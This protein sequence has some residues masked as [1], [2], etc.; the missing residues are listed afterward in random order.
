[1]GAPES[2]AGDDFH[3]WWAA[4]RAL[5]LIEPGAALR[6]ITLEGLASVDDPD[7]AYETVDVAEYVGGKDVATAQALVLSQLKYSTRHPDQA[8]TAARICKLRRRRKAD[9]S[10]T[11]PRSVIADLASAFR[12]LLDDHGTDVAAKARIALVS[13]QPGDSLL[14]SSVAAAADWLRTQGG[15]GH[16]AALLASLPAE[17]AAIIRM[18]SD[19]VDSRLGSGAFCDFLAA[20][21]LSQTGA[22]DRASLARA[23]R[24]GAAELTPG[25]GPDSARRLFHLVREEALPDSGH[26]GITAEDVLAE[27][28]APELFDLYPAPLRLPEIP[29]PLPAPGARAVADAAMRSLGG[30]VVAHGPAGAGKTTALRQVAAQL[31]AGSV[32][33]LFDC[34]GGGE[35]LS[36]GEE[37][38]T[39]QRFITQVVNE[40]AQR[41]G[42][43]LLVQPPQVGA[44]LWRRLGRTLERAVDVLDPG[45]VLVVAVDAADNAVVAASERGDRAFLSGLVGLR[46]PERVAVVLT[47]RSHRVPSLG[48]DGAVI[49]EVTPFDLATSTAHLRQH[50]P[51]APDADAAEF[52]SR[53]GGNPRA[54]FYALTQADANE[55]DMRA[56]LEACER[57][58]EPIFHDLVESALQV[59]GADAG[60]Q[61]WLALM[62]ALS[63]PVSTQTLA[64]ALGVAP[65][66]VAAFADG[67]AP[68]VKLADGAIQFRDEDFE[69]YVRGRVDPADVTAAH[70]RL[71]E[72]FLASRVADVDAAAHVADH[73]FDAGRYDEL[74]RL[75][76]EEDSPAGIADGFRREQ[77]QGRR[78]DLAARA[79]AENGGAAAAVRVA[80]RGCDTASR[81]DTLSRLVES[82]LDLVARYSDIDLLRA[83]ALRQDRDEWL[84]P[85]LMRL[86]AALSRD[87]EQHAAA[88]S[89]LDSADAWLRRWMAGRNG[90][91][92]HWQIEPDDVAG[93]AE[94]RYRLD[95]VAAA[96]AELRRWRPAEFAL[97]AAA[98]LASRVAG[99]LSPDEVRDALRANGVPPA[100]QA[101]V[102]GRAASA[103]AAPDPV[104]VHEVVAALM[105]G[106]AGEPRPWQTSM[107]DVAV[108]HGDQEAAAALARH[109]ARELP[110]HG[111]GFTDAGADGT[112]ILRCHAAAAAL[113]GTDLHVEEL[114]PTSLQPRRS[115]K[116]R[117][118]D[119]REHDRRQWTETVEPIVAAAVLAARAAAGHACADDVVALVDAAL[120]GRVAHAGHRWFT[121][122]RSYRAWATLIAEATID[123]GAPAAVLDRLTDAAPMLLRN[124]A[125]ELWLD[126]AEALARR[127]RHDDRVA[128]LC[129]RVAARARTD[130]YPASDRLDL[131]ARAA[132]I[133]AT[134]A[135]ELGKRLFDQAVDVATGINDDAARLLVVHADL[136][137]RAA[138]P[139]PD[140]AGVAARLVRAAE[141]VAPH[142][143]NSRVVPYEAVAGAAAQLDPTVG[144]AAA[145]RWDDEDRV[146]LASTLPAALAGA[147]DSGAVPAW[148]ALALD[149][150][151]EGDERRLDYQLD[152]AA[153]MHGGGAAGIAAA[154]V[155]LARAAAWLRSHVPAHD[156]PVL[157]RRLLD[158]AAARGLD[159]NV[160]A[161]LDP[162]CALVGAPDATGTPTS[163]RRS[164]DDPPPEAQALLAD[165]T[166]RGWEALAEDVATLDTAHIYG[167]EM[168]AFIAAVAGAAPPNQRV[169]ALAAITALPDRHVDTALAVLAECLDRWRDYPGVA[170]WAEAALPTLLA[171]HLPDLAWRQDTDRLLRQLRAF[172]DDDAVRRAILRALP[173]ARPQLTAYGWQNIAALLGRLC[174]PDDCTDAL[175]G[176]LDDR[177]PDDAADAT[178][179]EPVG[180]IPLLLWSAFGHPRREIRWRA[181]HAARD[182]LT[183]PDPAA[184]APLA[185]ALVRCL[186]RGDAGAFR[187][188]S[189]HFYPLSA[190]AGL[191]VALHRVAIDRPAVLAPHFTDLARHATSRDLPHAQIR[192]L[193][194]QAAIALANPADPA[195]DALRHA[196]QPVCCHTDRKRHHSPTDRRVSGNHRYRFDSLDTIPYWYAPL[197][198]VFDVPV[199]TVAEIAER[200]ILDRWGLGRDDWMTDAR[201]LRDERSWRRMSHGHGSIPPEENLRLYLEYHAMMVAAGELT[202]TR[203]PVRVDTWDA[204]DGDPWQD[205]LAPH[206]P[207]PGPWL[208]D[209]AAPV[210]TEPELF[211]HLPPLDDTWDTPAPADHDRALGVT[212]GRLPD[213][214]LVAAHT[215]LRRPGG[216]ESIY[217]WSALVAPDHAADLQRALAAATNPT[218]W[219]LPEEDDGEFEVDHGPF[220]LRGW[221]ANPRNHRD[222]LDKHDPYASEL[223]PA[224]PLP[225]RRFRDAVRAAPD[226]AGL[227]LVGLN[228]T[229][230][231]SAQQW[232]DPD[233]DDESGA[234][235]ASTGYRVRVDRAVL[236]RHLAGTGTS[237]IVEVQIGR[238]RSDSNG[239][240][241]FPRSRIY[242]LDAV[243]GVTAR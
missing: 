228:G 132:D 159:Q 241:R 81:M 135:P 160:R 198:Y 137:R 156:Q 34:Y 149:H 3:F 206:L 51:D 56:L 14:L 107:L 237:L 72:M 77:V 222:A 162:V 148:Q 27:L 173:A 48:A 163:R 223:L 201:E 35:Y 32:V 40:L 225:G 155:A 58:P 7:E 52:H 104:W 229:V 177:V 167:E 140:R 99:E 44:D 191:L 235:V 129:L 196:N 184:T 46:L 138:I 199:D 17:A 13:N 125:P 80:A 218:D 123:A 59:S 150:L 181:A 239:E 70:D 139:P 216:Y 192:E 110:T 12:R 185:A 118:A 166:S 26:D 161:A 217:V 86:A 188:P 186:D 37:R 100:A 85:V 226:P 119:P 74:L 203:R 126:L 116:E 151:V 9:G 78:L 105:T 6:R 21:D 24:A 180:P 142:V 143:T 11:A 197:A 83:H 10:A 214:I 23:V 202:D 227:A 63:R 195:L 176:L 240:Y 164:G 121:Y 200:W 208:V 54:Q 2:N 128:D 230:L 205:W 115:D 79:A 89:L 8:W 122:D 238:H 39:P 219:K 168:Q 211:G 147:V 106:P 15:R 33:V 61:R 130:P 224:L 94:A 4:G 67:L 84:G 231:A 96:I 113:G 134:T 1:V 66:A 75:V 98:A 234:S 242:L 193:A 41:C 95:G 47:A 194:R 170:E 204:D 144:L 109:W 190:T 19:A 174:G 69:T 29:D 43:P 50:R 220:Q 28:S 136:A 18:L 133:A 221:L 102:L 141:A 165:P 178:T 152:I 131:I 210:P 215:S 112:A 45:A 49:V 101:P 146:R 53:T 57:T 25:R 124:G 20:L 114:V 65:A 232:A 108:R 38:H 207:T 91:T 127:G 93:A 76:L 62:L 5:A 68:G 111:W 212:D 30:L 22:L 82:R 182:L 209:L 175:L 183:H 97:D 153:K 189:L 64:A 179:P 171:Q 169:D 16:R 31:P 103:A 55:W 42:T 236:L 187:D 157:A 120:A 71:A 60:G 213:P 90:E 243:G 233:A 154:R 92:Q 172:A 117:T 73:L 36:S 145:S 88:R 87:P 158:A